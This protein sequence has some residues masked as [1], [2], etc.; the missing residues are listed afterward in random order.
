MLIKKALHYELR[1]YYPD[2]PRPWAQQLKGHRCR[3]R[4]LPFHLCPRVAPTLSI[5][6]LQGRY[7]PVDGETL[8]LTVLVQTLQGQKHPFP[9]YGRSPNDWK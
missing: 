4:A 8:P 1:D 6:H 2:L 7:N 5:I 9:T 3:T